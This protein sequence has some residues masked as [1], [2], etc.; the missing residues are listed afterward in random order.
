VARSPWRLITF[1][2]DGTLTLVHGWREIA[3]AF[4]RLDGFDATNRQ[5]AAR[6]IGED[7]HLTNL[8]DLAAGHTVEEVGEVVARTPKLAGIAEGVRELHTWG[9]R[10][11]LLTHNPTYVADWYRRTFG[12]DD[13]AAVAAQPVTDGR[14]GRAEGA[15][16][17]KPGGM[18][19]L[20]AQYAIPAPTAVHVGDGLSDAQVFRIVGGGVAVNSPYPEVRKQ[21]DLALATQDFGQ[22]VRGLARL[23]PRK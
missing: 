15:H 12:F 11:A 5:F 14:I 23:T 1:D 16:A 10:V 7:R 20:L 22:V 2:I 8:L 17:D 9:A 19:A 13:S 6:T 18:R 3:R 21:A 4:G